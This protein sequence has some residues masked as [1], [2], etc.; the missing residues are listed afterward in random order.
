MQLTNEFRVNLPV[1]DAWQVLLDLER[2]GPCLPGASITGRDGE[3]YLGQAKIKVGPIT[4]TYKGTAKF[5]EVGE[6]GRRAVISAKAREARGGGDAQAMITATLTEDGN[7]TRVNVL[8]DLALTGKVAQFGRGVIVDVSQALLTTFA[9]RLEAMLA[10]ENEPDVPAADAA[11]SGG[12]SAPAGTPAPGPG[13]PALPAPPAAAAAPG[14]EALDLLALARGTASGRV[15]A[16]APF[17]VVA[18]IAG[19]LGWLLGRRQQ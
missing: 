3:D 17:A 5:V 8:T 12:S 15:P 2:V 6:P 10:A 16:A 14:D 19:L 18:V 1:A 7:A 4:A 11:P 13:R 9:D